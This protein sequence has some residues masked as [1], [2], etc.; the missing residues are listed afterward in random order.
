MSSC[1]PGG[2]P[3]RLTFA[4]AS[5]HTFSVVQCLLF[6]TVACAWSACRT[7]IG[8]RP[9]VADVK[10]QVELLRWCDAFV[11]VYPTWWCVRGW[12]DVREGSRA[13]AVVCL[14]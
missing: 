4:G 7:P 10:A 3:A 14:W 5:V 1:C 12:S 6:V 13:E 2:G 11:L 8:D 9:G